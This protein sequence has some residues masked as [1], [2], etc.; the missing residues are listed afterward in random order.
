[1]I[2]IGSAACYDCRFQSKL[3]LLIIDVTVPPELKITSQRDVL[4]SGSLDPRDDR[5]LRRD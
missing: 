4:E 2:P 3:L 5:E 1:M